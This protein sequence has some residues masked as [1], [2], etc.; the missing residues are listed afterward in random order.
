M[1]I[2]ELRL[3]IFEAALIEN[4][5]IYFDESVCSLKNMLDSKEDKVSDNPTPE[6]V[7]DTDDGRSSKDDLAM[8]TMCFYNLNPSS[9][10]SILE[11][12]GSRQHYW[13][14]SKSSESHVSNQS[15]S[16]I[17][18]SVIN[19]FKQARSIRLPTL[20]IY[21]IMS[22]TFPDMYT[23]EMIFD[24]LLKNKRI[25][26]MEKIPGQSQFTWN[27]KRSF[28]K[29]T[30]K[31]KDYNLT[32][33]QIIAS[34]LGNQMLTQSEIEERIEIAFPKVSGRWKHSVSNNLKNQR[35]FKNF[36][37][38]WYIGEEDLRNM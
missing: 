14:D 2:W 10:V 1:P 24:T 16:K 23:D 7:I 36:R 37:K 18:N 30:V 31:R 29:L 15:T 9:F 19:C 11:G 22:L 27:L 12:Q 38:E 28:R 5:T 13:E 6:L 4:S 17:L 35:C 32:W 3:K 33:K 20:D 21:S 26:G 34:V 25:F 8:E